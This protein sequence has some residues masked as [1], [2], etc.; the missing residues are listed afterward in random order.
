MLNSL[1][2]GITGFLNSNLDSNS[3]LI[4]HIHLY[5]S[6]F[7]LILFSIYAYKIKYIITKNML[8]KSFIYNFL[9]FFIVVVFNQIFN[10]NYWFTNQKPPGINLTNILPEFPYYLIVLILIGLT[11]YYLTY[12]LFSKK[13]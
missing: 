12:K 2:G 9:V 1:G 4:E 13:Y 10:S 5:L 6:H 8:F 3:L 11:S 7:N